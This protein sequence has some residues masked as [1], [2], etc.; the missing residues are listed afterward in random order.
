VCPNAGE[1]SHIS[2]STTV[3]A[4]R[5][6]GS[7][8][9]LA[10]VLLESWESPNMHAGSGVIWGIPVKR[11]QGEIQ[12]EMDRM[13][14]DHDRF[15]RLVARMPEPSEAQKRAITEAN[16]PEGWQKAIAEVIA[17]GRPHRRIA[18]L[19]LLVG[20]IVVAVAG[21]VLALLWRA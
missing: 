12:P 21:G 13:S 15:M 1:N 17:D 3:R 6:D 10:S 18:K 8:P 5:V 2:L 9:N 14:A 7:R 20:A 16:I 4:A 11:L 19:L